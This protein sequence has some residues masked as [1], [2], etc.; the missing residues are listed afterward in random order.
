[1]QPPFQESRCHMSRHTIVMLPLQGSLIV[2]EG[3]RRQAQGPASATLIRLPPVKYITRSKPST[4][5]RS[6]IQVI[7]CRVMEH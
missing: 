2:K 6:Y 3:I 5:T 4:S 1:M 7:S